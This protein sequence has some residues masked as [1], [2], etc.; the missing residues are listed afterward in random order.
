[1]RFGRRW[2]FGLV[3]LAGY[4][5]LVRPKML[6]W[7]ATDDERRQPFPGDD[8]VEPVMTHHT[9]AVT[10][11]ASPEAVWPW[12]VQIGD[13]RAGFYSYDW[14]ERFIFLG[15][16]HYI[17]GA[18]S[19]TRIHP[20]LQTVHVG[21]QINT[22][23]IGPV[24]L[25]SP[26]TILEPNHAF[27]MGTW[28]FILEPLAQQRTRL[29]VRERDAGWLRVLTPRRFGLLRAAA[30]AFDYIIGEPLHFAMDRKMMLGLKQ[31]AEHSSQSTIR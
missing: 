2:G 3:A 22:G 26:V 18:H 23:S 27:V 13:S 28:A 9:R 19:A 30:A 1:V 6:D 5:V 16:V 21:D 14:V 11:N 15:T 29:L 24:K 25:G 7:G 10:I 17:E 4:D 8:I 20:E 12:L 31:R